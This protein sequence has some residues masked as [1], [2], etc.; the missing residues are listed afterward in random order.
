[1]TILFVGQAGIPLSPQQPVTPRSRRIEQLGKLLAQQGHEVTIMAKPTYTAKAIT[2]YHG[3]TIKKSRLTGLHLLTIWR[4]QPAVIHIHGW[5]LPSLMWLI[6]LLSPKSILVWTVDEIPHL[7]FWLSR[8]IA[9]QAAYIADTVTTTTRELQY[10]T[11]INFSVRSKYIPDGFSLPTIRD[12][13]A[14]YFGLVKG[15]YCLVL[16]TQASSLKLTIQGYKEAKSRK[17]LVILHET[18]PATKRLQKR[19]PFLYF[20]APASSRALT[21]IIRQAAV[22]ILADAEATTA[23][24]LH[25]MGGGRAIIATTAPLYQ[26]TLGVTGHYYAAKDKNGLVKA[27]KKVL[28]KPTAQ[29]KWGLKAKIR[30][31]KHFT[32]ERLLPEYLA[33]YTTIKDFVALDSVTSYYT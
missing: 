3:I 18:T 2:S 9:R 14:Q 26:E 7:P 17:K 28:G 5:L 24:L 6:A 25:A 32:W 23:S 8:I 12:I 15:Q 10:N 31:T 1:M 29:R 22:V 27:F 13:P 4:Y 20:I 21:S 16:A 19:Y 33:A 30:S 11:L